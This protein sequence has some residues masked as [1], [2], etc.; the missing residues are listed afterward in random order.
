MKNV[1]L[2]LLTAL[3]FSCSANDE[4]VTT[5]EVNLAVDHYKTTSAFNGTA[6]V[7][8]E[9]GSLG[10]ANAKVYGQIDNFNFEPG[11]TY[12]LSAT[13]TITENAGTNAKTV[14]YRANTVNSRQAARPD[15]NF[16]IP[17]IEFIN[18]RGMATFIRR[19][20]DSTFILG[21]EI[22][23]DCNYFC[24]DL[25]RAIEQENEVIGIFSHG[26]EGSYVL[27]ELID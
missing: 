10:D 19:Q 22:P 12:N 21:N 8:Y 7:I 9:N 16:R 15:A 20:A 13:K 3:I 26:P 2:L 6:F 14:R 23:F 18:G 24:L 17:M 11:F 5:E 4:S 1:I 25:D 27:N